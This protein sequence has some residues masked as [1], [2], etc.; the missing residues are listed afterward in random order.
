M[1]KEIYNGILR[2][3]NEKNQEK[4][5]EIQ[6]LISE[7]IALNN[8]K[9]LCL[10]MKNY[11]HSNGLS[12]YV[13]N[14]IHNHN[15]DATN[16]EKFEIKGPLGAGLELQPTGTYVGFAAGTGVLVFLDLVAHLILRLVANNG[17]INIFEGQTAPLVDITSF[18]LILYTSFASREEAI[19]LEMLEAL[20]SACKNYGF[21]NLFEH[22]SRITNDPS[23]NP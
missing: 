1:R 15:Q 6:G 19:G 23:T 17:E 20:L 4:T 11:N 3:V 16:K 8:T 9:T 7:I 13:Y 22:N 21:N 2:L 18:K 12:A 14:S 5:L 10:T